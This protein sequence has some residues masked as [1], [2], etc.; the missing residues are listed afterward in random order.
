[1]GGRWLANLVLLMVVVVLGAAAQREL[2]RET[3]R[4]TDIDPTTVSRIRLDRP[5]QPPLVI[6]RADGGWRLEAPEAM[7]AD[8]A[9]VEALL[10]VAQAIIRGTLPQ[11]AESASLGLDPPRVQLTIDGVSLAFGDTEPLAQRRYVAL[12]GVLHLIE[13][14]WWHLLT[15]PPAHFSETAPSRAGSR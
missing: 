10:G 15:A 5:Q 6:A 9:R 12:G 7:P 11:G 13:D 14:R 3:P 4:L 1:M 2:E 8:R